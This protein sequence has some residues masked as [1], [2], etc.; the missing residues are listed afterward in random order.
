MKNFTITAMTLLAFVA[1]AAAGDD[2]AA[3][4]KKAAPDPKADPKAA[5]V[6]APEPTP[7]PAPPAQPDPPAEMAAA[8]KAMRGTWRC[9]GEMFDN[10]ENPTVGRKTKFTIK[11]TADL[12]K[13][14]LKAD[15]VEAKAKGLKY[16]FKFTSYKTYSA[17]DSKWHQVM[18]DNWGSISTG[19]STGPDAAGKTVWELDMSM[20]GQTVKFRDYE[21]PGTKKRS[22]HM[23]GEMTEN[24]KEW[25]KVY[26]STCTK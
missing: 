13:F 22:I 7:A 8:I 24:G 18:V 11:V 1:T 26:D 6:K 10:M 17:A 23:W 9:T 12:D 3:E 2:K 16:P 20:M 5:Q 19:W 4:K 15:F 25:K 14:W 21:E